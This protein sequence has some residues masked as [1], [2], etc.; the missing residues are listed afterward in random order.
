MDHAVERELVVPES[1]EEVWRSLSE[2]EWL[3][4]DAS[5]ELEPAGDV[6]AGERSGFVEEVEEPRRLVF[7]WSEEDSEST[8]VEI[9]LEETAD[10]TRVLVVESRPLAV[11]D[12]RGRDLATELGVSHGSGPQMSAGPLL[13]AR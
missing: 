5:I 9:D 1:P 13:L 4:E 8:R 2:P 10:G 7:W 12:A 11:L 3:G 6:R